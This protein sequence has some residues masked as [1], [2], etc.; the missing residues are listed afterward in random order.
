MS[1]RGNEQQS[2]TERIESAEIAIRADRK[3]IKALERGEEKAAL[4]R[5][6]ILTGV[7][8]R[9]SA[10]EKSPWPDGP[11][12]VLYEL[13]QRV[14][15]LDK[16][17]AS[18][19]QATRKVRSSLSGSIAKLEQR[20]RETRKKLV[21]D[22]LVG[23][24]E[25]REKVA[26]LVL[27]KPDVADEVDTKWAEA[28][29]ANTMSILQG[30]PVTPPTEPDTGRPFEQAKRVRCAN[31]DEV[32]L[33]FIK[34][35]IIGTGK[36]CHTVGEMSIWHTKGVWTVWM[37]PEGSNYLYEG[38]SFEA[39]IDAAIDGLRPGAEHAPP[40]DEAANRKERR[41]SET[42]PETQ[43]E[44]APQMT[45]GG[46]LDSILDHTKVDALLDATEPEAQPTE[47]GDEELTGDALEERLRLN[48]RFWMGKCFAQGDQIASLKAEV[49]SMK[50][51][52][53]GWA[54]EH[55][56]LIAARDEAQ[57]AC[58]GLVKAL[59]CCREWVVASDE[60]NCG[61]LGQA[62]TV[63]MADDALKL[64]TSGEDLL[65]GVMECSCT[66]CAE[67]LARKGREDEPR[68]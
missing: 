8:N 29:Q 18:N 4:V 46:G 43:P 41:D 2:D 10:L 23:L 67:R 37:P 36:T 28:V 55:A 58:A 30:H 33:T 39:A 16:A 27:H 19:A 26:K 13:Q 51:A 34:H 20:D 1:R 35:L 60:P 57:A 15:R 40:E 50:Q 52:S 61:S 68:D 48:V 9:I 11:K 56:E 53:D 66:I 49:A 25:V 17:Q 59:K 22:I 3:R 64:D 5:A 14:G 63:G 6:G 65:P 24:N 32:R 12:R 21:M 42:W 45:H 7:Q 47:A 54:K 44:Q 62:E 38:D 31:E